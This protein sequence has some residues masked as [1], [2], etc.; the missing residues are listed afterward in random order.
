MR[1]L[2]IANAINITLGPC[3][4]FGIGPFPKLG[5]TG[6]AIGTSIGRWTG[7]LIQLYCFT[8]KDGRIRIRLPHLR[9]DPDVMRTIVSISG[10]ATFQSFIGTASYMAL[11]RIISA[12]GSAAIAGN[13]IG[14]RIFLFALLPSWGIS[15]AATTL[16]GQNLGAGH[17]DR[18]EES[19]WKICV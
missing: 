11:V 4:I 1:V 3:L 12:F 14:I 6:A 18:A 19:A 8:R 10:A 5:V 2:W 7:V 13:T 16:V 9:L 17:P 15:N